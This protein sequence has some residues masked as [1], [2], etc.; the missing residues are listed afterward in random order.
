VRTLLL[1]LTALVPLALA[2]GGAGDA[3]PKLAFT[4]WELEWIGKGD[5]CKLEFLPGG[6]LSCDNHPASTGTYSVSGKD[7][8]ID[9][10]DGGVIYEGEFLD[11][12]TM[13]GSYEG[14]TGTT[15]SWRARRLK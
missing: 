13:G 5:P 9:Y 7:V 10:N 12:W 2:C 6:T 8:H 3:E 11:N 14:H 4:Q 1:T 15:G